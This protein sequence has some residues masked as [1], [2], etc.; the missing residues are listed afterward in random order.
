MPKKKIGDFWG[1]CLL[2]FFSFLIVS[3]ISFFLHLLYG[4]RLHSTFSLTDLWAFSPDQGYSV[5]PFSS[6]ILQNKEPPTFSSSFESKPCRCSFSL[7]IL[8]LFIA[9]LFAF[10]ILPFCS[11]IIIAT[12]NKGCYFF[13]WRCSSGNE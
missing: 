1:C 9:L 12:I 4:I 8:C 11:R 13:Q 7:H 2:L 6:C 5:P 3:L 10:L